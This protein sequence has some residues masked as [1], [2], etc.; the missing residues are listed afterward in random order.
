MKEEKLFF[1]KTKEQSEELE[2]IKLTGYEDVLSRLY[3]KVYCYEE[4]GSYQGDWPAKVRKGNEVFWLLG[5]YGSCSGCDWFQAKEDYPWELKCGTFENAKKM[6]QK[7][8][9]RILKEFQDNYEAD[10]FTQDEIEKHYEAELKYY[11]DEDYK[12]MLDFVKKYKNIE[13]EEDG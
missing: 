12:E 1:P 5:Y 9:D 3:D 6:L 13:T 7:E 11:D 4:F 8:T 2:S 10:K